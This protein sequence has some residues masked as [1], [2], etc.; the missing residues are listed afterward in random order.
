MQLESRTRASAF[1]YLLLVGVFASFGASAMAVSLRAVAGGEAVIS[2]C[3]VRASRLKPLPTGLSDVV[4]RYAQIPCSREVPVAVPVGSGFS[5][6]AL[7]S[8]GEETSPTNRVREIPHG[9]V[10]CSGKNE[11]ATNI[12]ALSKARTPSTSSPAL[13]ETLAFPGAEGFGR[14]ARGGR[15][16]KV[17]TV[18]HLGEEGP[19]S[20]RAAIEAQGPRTIVFA[21]SGTIHLTRPLRIEH[22]FI[23]IVGQT[24]P[25]DGITL[26]D[27]TLIIAANDVVIRF[28]RSR[29]GN[30]SGADDDDAIWVSGGTRVILD[31]ISASWS[32]DE[33]L[34]VSPRRA[35]N[36]APIGDITVQW[37][38]ITESLNRSRH[39]KGA[40]GYGSLV[41]GWRGSRYS[42]HHNLWAHHRARMPRP[43]NY[44]S[45]DE[46]PVGAL[47]DF[48]NNVFYNWG[49]SPRSA[50]GSPAVVAAG[51]DV[52]SDSVV[53]YNFINNAYRQGIDSTAA[54]AFFEANVG[55]RAYFSGNTMD[56][57]LPRDPW[58]L[59]SGG[60]H[61]GY[62]Q[63]KPIV[64][65]P[66]RTESADRAFERVLRSSGA[67]LARD[68]VDRRV[69]A[70]LRAGKGQ[71]IDSQDDV[72]G[73]PLMQSLPAPR[74]SDGDGMPD[75]WEIHHG[76]DPHVADAG[77]IDAEGY[78]RLER[79]LDELATNQSSP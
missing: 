48:R 32:T 25:G 8:T 78:T 35:A 14:F 26:R 47:M 9:G 12:I 5:R 60:T 37:S 28:L 52:D 67:S 55:A 34:S 18:T 24:A 33:V 15:G 16:G 21:V 65:A 6:D 40:H 31:H 17:F 45:H 56:G 23:T 62:R 30:E 53:A 49:A 72:G 7:G 66:V 42:F 73:W 76:F 75:A 50:D 3:G 61:A 54:L 13:R 64:V 77:E 38:F 70:D 41:R 1:S 4:H 43:G 71:I 11:S 10:L 22:G 19:G 27:Q 63:A 36:D 69:V 29:L 57:K 58:S 74:D 51:Y 68:A 79:Y 44:A 46:D 2:G 39:P 20:L 59:I